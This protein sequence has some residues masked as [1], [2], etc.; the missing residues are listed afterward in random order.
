MTKNNNK[1]KTWDPIKNITVSA[2]VGY[3]LGD[4]LAKLGLKRKK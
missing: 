3:T 2:A 1:I 4:I